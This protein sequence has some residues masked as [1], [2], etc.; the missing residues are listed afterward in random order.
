MRHMVTLRKGMQGHSRSRA[1]LLFTH[2]L[3]G[4]DRTTGPPPSAKRAVEGDLL[5]GTL[6]KREFLIVQSCD[7]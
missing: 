6:E 2:D 1:D 7:E 4:S 3:C 5:Q